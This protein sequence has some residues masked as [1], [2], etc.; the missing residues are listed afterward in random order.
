MPAA[1]SA[2]AGRAAS[3]HSA[4]SSPRPVHFVL[5][6]E[7][8]FSLAHRRSRLPPPDAWNSVSLR[9]RTSGPLVTREREQNQVGPPPPQ[10]KR[11]LGQLEFHQGNTRR[12]IL[13]T[14]EKSN[15]ARLN[16]WWNSVVEEV[17]TI[18]K[19]KSRN[20]GRQREKESDA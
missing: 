19:K 7:R 17:T 11:K 4:A 14:H 13:N 20:N 10:K 8:R 1:V 9:R 18:K 12:S 16:F 15:P 2:A 3:F 5:V 6:G